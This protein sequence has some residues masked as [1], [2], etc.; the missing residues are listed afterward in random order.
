[1]NPAL[2]G[3]SAAI[4]W[5]VHDLV[6]GLTSRKI[7]FVQTV[8]WVTLFGLLALTAALAI[9]DDFPALN[10]ST[11]ALPA[12]AG[13]LYLVAALFLFAALSQGPFSLAAPIS[14]SFPLTSLAFAAIQGTEIT[15]LQLAASLGVVGGVVMV[16]L[17]GQD[18]QEN[19]KWGPASIRASILCAIGAHVCFA[20]AIFAG[21]IA[22]ASIGTLQATWVG[23]IAGLV[24]AALILMFLRKSPSC[25][26][27]ML[28][29]LAGIGTL[30]ATAICLLNAAG[31]TAQPQIA[32][33][34][35]SAFGVI[36]IML[37]R[38]FLKEKI[39]PLRWTGIAVT[40]I[41]VAILS[42]LEGK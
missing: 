37:A 41:G 10:A 7:G 17:T 39:P 6:G 22:S 9:L 4:F 2:L 8:F 26:V 31:N 14:G 24:L 33:V 36:T 5:G 18:E 35:G 23:R 38:F 27:S 34:A 11:L 30:D 12:V 3:A 19:G 28:L 15:A 16:S 32:S 1:M 40:F 20:A 13:S 29:T 21:Q 25:R 42:G